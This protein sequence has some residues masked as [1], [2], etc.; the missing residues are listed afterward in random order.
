MLSLPTLLKHIEIFA[1]GWHSSTL[2]HSSPYL[3]VAGCSCSGMRCQL[4]GWKA[5]R[6]RSLLSYA[7]T[8]WILD[9]HSR[10]AFSLTGLGWVE[11]GVG[12]AVGRWL[13]CSEWPGGYRYPHHQGLIPSHLVSTPSAVPVSPPPFPPLC[14]WGS[15]VRGAPCGML[16]G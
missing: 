7:S 4:L 3:C 13:G 11:G 10:G 9:C 16:P 15:S 6:V 2:L 14:L 5:L 1:G 8:P 12:G